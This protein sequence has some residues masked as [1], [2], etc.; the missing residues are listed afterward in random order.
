MSAIDTNRFRDLL[1]DH[2][3]QVTDALDYLHHENPGSMEDETDEMPLDNHLAE[4]ATITY[5]RELDYTLGENSEQLL[6]LIDEA[7]QRINDGTYGTCQRCAQP[8]AEAR[9][10]AIPYARLC[11][12]CKRLEER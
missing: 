4:M 5:D 2:R 11:I 10:E 6:Q 9:L 3:K 12:D 8:I 1:L 7:L